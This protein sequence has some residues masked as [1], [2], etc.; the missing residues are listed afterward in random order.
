M[1]CS[2][3]ICSCKTL[4]VLSLSLN[5]MSYKS[6]SIF[7]SANLFCFAVKRFNW[8]TSL[9]R[10]FQLGHLFSPV[11]YIFYQKFCHR[12]TILIYFSFIFCTLHFKFG[13]FCLTFDFLVGTTI[14]VKQCKMGK[15]RTLLYNPK[16]KPNPHPHNAQFLTTF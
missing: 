5:S 2:C 1:S 3:L 12:F 14:I 7:I 15:L 10:A 13:S 16:Q 6:C 8:A 9:N 11:F 4:K